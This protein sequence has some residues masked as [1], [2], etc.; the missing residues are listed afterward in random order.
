MFTS[1]KF[2]NR[3]AFFSVLLGGAV[4]L[5]LPGSAWAHDVKDPVCRMTVDS[6]TTPFKQ[7]IGGKTFHFCSAT[8]RKTFGASP[9]K[10][11]KLAA[12]LEKSAGNTYAAR[13]S[14]S[15]PAL[16]GKPTLLNIRIL[17]D[18]TKKAVRD[19][20]LTHEKKMHFLLV[21]EDM[22]WFSHE[23]PEL[24]NDGVFRLRTTFPRPGRYHLYADFTPADGDNQIL[25]MP[26]SV[27][28]TGTKIVAASS[29][30]PLTPDTTLTRRVND[31]SISVAVQ[32]KTLRQEQSAIL[33]YTLRDSQGRPIRDF[34][35]YLGAM[36]HLMAIRQ[37]GKEV[38]HTHALHAVTPG[39]GI[40]EEGGLHLTPA[41][42]T[43]SG[44]AF[45]FKVSL[46]STGIYKIWAQFQRK[47]KVITV[48]FT[49]RVADIWETAS[50]Q[51][52]AAKSA[53]QIATVQVNGSGYS[54]KNLTVV[55]GK[56]V[57]VTFIG[58]KSLGCGD[59]LVFPELGIKKTL[60]PS[61]RTV[62]RFTPTKSGQIRFTCGMNMY[63]GQVTVTE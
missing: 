45:S 16:A 30:R 59:T 62:V 4:L 49:F 7:K 41:M 46:P 54:P 26:F 33:T 51:E 22:A 24:G 58:G 43:A 53:V 18:G 42:S 15:A 8:C 34:E 14:T 5:S 1:T 31:L 47:G 61:G 36:G 35:P 56:P 6:D 52:V 25:A 29:A 17:N 44:P 55:A 3:R 40:K 63:R 12:N 27:G 10:Y 57:E 21:S 28:G 48:P 23:H 13:V 9:A 38:V 11:T 19:F 50:A 60:T 2:V 39:K 20:E 32:P 37:D